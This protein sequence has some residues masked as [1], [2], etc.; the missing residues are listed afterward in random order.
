MKMNIIITGF[1]G[2]GKSAVAKEL[3][4]K[5]GMKCLDMDK[6]IEERQGMTISDIFARY[7]EQYFR[8]QENNLVKEISSKE[9]IVVATGGGTFISLDNIKI[10]SQ[11]GNIVCLYADSESIYERLKIENNRPL[12]KGENVL[13][14][15]N[16]LLEKRK[17]VYDNFH[18]K[19]DTSNL[20]I[21]GV[22]EQIIKL[23][24]VR[25]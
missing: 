1:M 17:K 19:V 25:R 3:A 20:S 6:I 10:M 9:N 18:L 13:E 21:Q 4:Q 5:L 11:K 15:I 12:L 14:K 7:G 8:E 23:L 24:K 22:V 2:T 16:Y